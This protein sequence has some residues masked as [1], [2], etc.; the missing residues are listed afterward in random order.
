M[1]GYVRVRF[2]EFDE[3]DENV[4]HKKSALDITIRVRKPAGSSYDL[5]EENR[6]IRRA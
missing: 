1:I 4:E 5:P 6:R 2:D 3:N